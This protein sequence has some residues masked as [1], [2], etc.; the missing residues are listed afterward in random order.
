MVQEPLHC[1]GC[2]CTDKPLYNGWCQECIEE[3]MFNAEDFIDFG[4]TIT[5]KDQFNVAL[6]ELLGGVESANDLLE[7]FVKDI[8]KHNYLLFK[9]N[10]KN[11]VDKHLAEMGK[12]LGEH[13]P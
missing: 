13:R 11:F 2:D 6:V 3:N 12:W 5:P 1:K 8:Y 4:K 10:K 7:L 9:D